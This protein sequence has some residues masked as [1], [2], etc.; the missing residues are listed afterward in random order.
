MSLKKGD[1]VPQP[2]IGDEWTIR[3]STT[4]AARGW[5]DL[6][7]VAC[8]NLRKAWDAMR[9]SPGPGPAQRTN[10]HHRLVGT[11]AHE[12][13]RGRQLPQWQI[14]VTSGG[15]IWYLLDEE[16]RTVWVDYAGTQHPKETE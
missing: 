16:K 15:R 5:P 3:F 2:A 7:I 12:T 8:G 13:V 14:E 10:R 1:L 4:K 9:H 11:L 6:E